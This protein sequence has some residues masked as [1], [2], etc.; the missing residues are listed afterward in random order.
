MNKNPKINMERKMLESECL[1][2]DYCIMILNNLTKKNIILLLIIFKKTY[3]D[4]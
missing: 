1:Y 3:I 2:L 4:Y